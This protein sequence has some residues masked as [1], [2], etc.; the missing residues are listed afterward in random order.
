MIVTD[1]DWLA[2]F[3]TTSSQ[4]EKPPKAKK[5]KQ[6]THQIEAGLIIDKPH[7]FGIKPA[8][9]AKRTTLFD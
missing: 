9:P 4:L 5:Q 1:P 7:L 8:R 3:G 2:A 6:A